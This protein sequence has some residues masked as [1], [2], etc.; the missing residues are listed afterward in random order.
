MY[1]VK[2]VLH[3]GT[4][5]WTEGKSWIFVEFLVEASVNCMNLSGDQFLE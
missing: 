5:G 4:R 2:E 1:V 3:G